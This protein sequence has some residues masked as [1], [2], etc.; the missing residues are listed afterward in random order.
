M[1]RRQHE[2]GLH[3]KTR[4]SPIYEAHKLVGRKTKALARGYLCSNLSARAAFHKLG[5]ASADVVREVADVIHSKTTKTAVGSA[6]NEYHR[7]NSPRRHGLGC[8]RACTEVQD[9]AVHNIL[10]SK[11]GLHVLF[12]KRGFWRVA[13]AGSNVLADVSLAS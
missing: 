10:H 6:W 1:R 2:G 11:G 7:L 3:L 8:L 4:Q 12:E 9:L 13:H 5:V